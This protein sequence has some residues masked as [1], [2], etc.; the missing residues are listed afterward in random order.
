MKSFKF[1]KKFFLSIFLSFLLLM[2]QACGGGNGSNDSG[3]NS[4]VNS[5]TVTATAGP[6][7]SITAD[8]ATVNGVPVDVVEGNTASYTLSPDTG[9]RIDSVTGCGGA[10]SGNTYTTAP[11]TA[12]CTINAS[13][14]INS[15]TVSASAGAGGNISPAS[16]SV[17]YGASTSFT[18]TADTGYSIASVT[19]CGGT[20]SGNSYTTAAIT[21][22][23]S[24]SASF[25]SIVAQPVL[26][27]VAVKT[28]R[29][30]WTDVAGAS[31]YRLLEDVDG[32]S[33]FVQVSGDIPQGSQ[34][35]DHA[36]NL[37]QRVNARYVLQTCT[38]GGC[39]DSSSISVDTTAMASAIGYFKASNTDGTE[40]GDRF[41][42][43]S[44]AISGDG[45]TLV[46]GAHG[47]D[48]PARG[49]NTG[50]QTS[51]IQ[52][53]SG[54]VYVFARDASGG[55]AQQAYI[56]ASNAEGAGNSSASWQGDFF[57]YSTSLS[58]DGNT[59]VVG[60]PGEDSGI[61]GIN[62]PGA[63]GDNSRS[64][65]GAAYV[66]SRSGTD[67]TQQA[68]IR[69][70][71]P[72]NGARFGS[73]VSISSDGTRIA[74]GA[75]SIKGH[76]G[77]GTGAVYV[78]SYSGTAW[79]QQQ[80]LNASNTDSFD[81]FGLAVSLSGL[82]NTLAVGALHEDSGVAGINGGATAEADNS[83]KD[84]GASYVFILDAANNW[85]QQAYIKASNPDA[86]DYFGHVVAL[87]YS[88]NTLVVSATREDSAGTGVNSGMQSDNSMTD[89]GAAY[90]FVR[91]SSGNWT[92]QAYIKA[93]NSDSK[94]VFGGP[95]DNVSTSST[96]GLSADGNTLVIGAP[97][98]DSRATGLQG[99]Q[100]DNSGGFNGAAYVFVRNGSTWSQQ[101]YLKPGNLGGWFGEG[102]AISADGGSI[103]VGAP[104][105]NSDA[106]GVGGDASNKNAP[107]SGAAY[108]Y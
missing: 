107:F 105:E 12:D 69:A 30:S 18:L 104:A 64:S 8:R 100:S 81:T 68:Y 38:Q 11:I 70:S 33:G 85:V 83:M 91:D 26:S 54:A 66:F 57:G 92:Q 10:L 47:E 25:A 97:G 7:G 37:H 52:Y 20:L 39:I 90:V 84:A 59:L 28:F 32:V 93:G 74:V 22:D 88:G 61:G 73:S 45:N 55:W 34:Q 29:F 3:N 65:S 62:S 89:A 86:S 78:F 27:Y 46:V 9:Y 23:C 98:E 103:L 51:N 60:A 58:D 13:F 53:S 36:V 79:S 1:S 50:D 17:D 96:L 19:G 48:S 56:K 108:L 77:S 21:A 101:V 43:G 44:V 71:T 4:Q 87:D 31:H 76:L 94:D 95:F 41:A 40:G 75:P 35:Y 49:I 42:G 6:G 82:G 24:V 16:S 14:I 5:Y 2:L 80:M 72:A 15:Y 63:Q 102:T 99:D 106:T 67:W